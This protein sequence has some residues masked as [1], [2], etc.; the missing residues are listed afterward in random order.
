MITTQD[1]KT[2][3]IA[4]REDTLTAMAEAML[5]REYYKLV[6]LA[7]DLRDWLKIEE[8]CDEGAEFQATYT[9]ILRGIG[10][11]RIN[12]LIK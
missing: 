3:C 10:P 11:Y 1:L 5:D 2:K 6:E 12:L 7:G 8:I 4:K 9:K